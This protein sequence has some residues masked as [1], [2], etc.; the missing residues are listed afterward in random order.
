MLWV[1]IQIFGSLHINFEHLSKIVEV[2]NV[3]DISELI[4]FESY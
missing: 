1:N 2:L 4:D 3:T